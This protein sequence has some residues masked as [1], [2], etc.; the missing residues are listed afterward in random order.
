MSGTELARIAFKALLEDV[1]RTTPNVKGTEFVLKTN[2]VLRETTALN[3][4]W[5]GALRE[6]SA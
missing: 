3:P 5:S 6:E 1:Q 2:L 4:R